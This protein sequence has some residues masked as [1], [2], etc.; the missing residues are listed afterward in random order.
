MATRTPTH[1][2]AP[3]PEVQRLRA[4]ALARADRCGRSTDPEAQFQLAERALS[5][6]Q[7]ARRIEQSQVRS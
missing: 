1:P 5:L 7:L 6:R 2:H 3:A 4:Q